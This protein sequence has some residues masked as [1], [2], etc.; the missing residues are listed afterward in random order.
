MAAVCAQLQSSSVHK[1]T[2]R[3]CAVLLKRLLNG[4]GNEEE[5]TGLEDILVACYNLLDSERPKIFSYLIQIIT[6]LV[7]RSAACLVRSCNSF[8]NITVCDRCMQNL[9][10]LAFLKA[11]ASFRLPKLCKITAGSICDGCKSRAHTGD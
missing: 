4:H 3:H 8:T 6:L 9:F 7:Q 2:L 11:P 5:L 1:S 10:L